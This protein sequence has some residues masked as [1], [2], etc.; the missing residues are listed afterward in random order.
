MEN[1]MQ[2]LPQTEAGLICALRDM[3]TPAPPA[4]LLALLQ[5]PKPQ[6]R[7]WVWAVPATL[8]TGLTA[9]L[10]VT[11]SVPP[12]IS[13]A[14]VA[15][16][17]ELRTQYTVVNTRVLG[18][19]RKLS[20]PFYR[21]GDLWRS[22]DSY[23]L[24]DRTVI[25]VKGFE[26]AKFALI[27]ERHEPRAKEFSIA[28]MMRRG[29]KVKTERNVLWNGRRVDRFSV[30][31][32]YRDS[33]RTQTFDQ[34]VVADPKT[35]L[36]IRMSI[37]RDGGRWGDI[38]D[39]TFERPAP[40]VFQ[41]TIPPDFKIYDLRAQRKELPS[42]L[43]AGQVG[44]V[45][46]DEMNQLWVLTTASQTVWAPAKMKIEGL[47]T[48]F[49]GKLS[50]GFSL[51]EEPKIGARPHPATLRIGGKDWHAVVMQ[52]NLQDRDLVQPIAKMKEVSGVFTIDGRTV[53]YKAVPVVHTGIVYQLMNTLLLG[54]RR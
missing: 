20:L 13:L 6:S 26:P 29:E 11:L 17:L 4:D 25:I 33:G 9:F 3:A 41:P 45:L 12:A 49:E 37:M 54:R 38:W 21:D 31:T 19:G 27:D 51:G 18:G 23:G 44:G 16:A 28:K 48:T 32:T 22:H 35:G 50:D 40:S 10:V 24:R 34:F 36:P 1:L 46:I 5:A 15:T 43:S 47:P 53:E 30:K 8:A 42:Q 39:Y 14:Q 7:G 2:N 52:R